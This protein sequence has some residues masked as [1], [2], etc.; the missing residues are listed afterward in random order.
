MQENLKMHRIAILALRNARP[1]EI[2]GPA[3]VFNEASRLLG[4]PCSYSVQIFGIATDPISVTGG[5]RLLPDRTIDDAGE[6]IDTLIAAGSSRTEFE[7]AVVQWLARRFQTLRRCGAVGSGVFLL[8]AAGLLDGHRATAHWEYAEKLAADY[9]K[10]SVERDRIFVRDGS[11]Y[12]S[13]GATA[14]L[15]LAL[16]L[17]EEDF[18][19]DLALA[20]AR[21]LVMFVKR[22]GGQVQVSAH[23]AAQSSAKSNI[24][25]VQEWVLDNLTADHSI[26]ALSRRAA[27]SARN[28]SRVFRRETKVT[29]AEFVEMARMQAARQMLEDTDVPLQRLAYFCG[30]HNV[31]TMRRSFVRTLGMR[32]T[33]YRQK[34]RH[35]SRSSTRVDRVIPALRAGLPPLLDQHPHEWRIAPKAANAANRRTRPSQA[36]LHGARRSQ[37]SFHAV[38]V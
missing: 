8:G 2:T 27:M 37:G 3:E 9:P 35:E 7:P 11:I 10:A 14:G 18:G 21:R 13:A 28:F 32:P 26:E 25:Q 19:R 5:L 24:Q 33:E 6:R 16:E 36:S 34:F 17:V 30:F 38:Q 1:I 29:P 20:V 23:L 22:P 31:E 4:E 12:T 15:D